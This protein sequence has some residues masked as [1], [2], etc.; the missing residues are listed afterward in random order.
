MNM[1]SSRE[2]S[3]DPE[4]SLP[5]IVLCEW[6][7]T[8]DGRSV[9]WSA[10]RPEVR[11]EGAD[12]RDALGGFFEEAQA[13]F[14]ATMVIN[15]VGRQPVDPPFDG[16]ARYDDML[17]VGPE[18][19]I[20]PGERFAGPAGLYEGGICP[21]CRE[22]LSRRNATVLELDSVPST[23]R[24][25]AVRVDQFRS[26]SVWPDVMVKWMEEWEP[27][28]GTRFRRV[29][30]L[31]ASCAW[32]E[33]VGPADTNAVAVS[34][35]RSRLRTTPCVA[36]GRAQLAYFVDGLPCNQFVFDKAVAGRHVAV[37]EG[38]GLEVAMAAAT[39]ADLR[40][41]WPGAAVSARALGLVSVDRIDTHPFS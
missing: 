8:P 26:V 12:V 10:A 3:S 9:I 33:L 39:V 17:L 34:P 1:G 5:P 7:R 36:C 23:A 14:G 20:E 13:H 35:L 19:S 29:R 15:F 2:G 4:E 30:L 16:L 21:A 31:G 6:R 22:P 32:S 37:I 27:G 18:D 24:P 28:I 40:S 25:C 41:R 11:A 38:V